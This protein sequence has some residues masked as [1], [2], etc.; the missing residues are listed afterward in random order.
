M[1]HLIVPYP[2]TVNRWKTPFQGRAVLTAEAREYKEAIGDLLRG[3]LAAPLTCMLAM[4][5]DVFRPRAAGDLDGTLK[6]LLDSLQGLVFVNDKQI[7]KLE[8]ELRQ[9]APPFGRVQ[10]TIEPFER[11]E[12]E[13]W[14][15][16]NRY[17]AAFERARDRHLAA[18]DGARERRKAKAGKAPP[19]TLKGLATSA[20]YRR[21]R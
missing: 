2:P 6:V 12:S 9:E 1:I 20:S 11:R 8:P 5:V 15:M 17:L 13:L 21:G 18:R 10:L 7:A 14:F 16:D 3:R 19:R 4:T